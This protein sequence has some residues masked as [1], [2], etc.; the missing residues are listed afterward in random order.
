MRQFY[1][2]ERGG[3]QMAASLKRDSKAKWDWAM[4]VVGKENTSEGEKD[5]KALRKVKIAT[6]LAPRE[7]HRFAWSRPRR[8]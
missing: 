3:S 2:A 1:F 7:R 8:R 4:V 6:P 5:I